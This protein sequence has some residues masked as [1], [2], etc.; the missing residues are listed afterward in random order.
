MTITGLNS[1][2]HHIAKQKSHL[3][4]RCW[5]FS[6]HKIDSND[7]DRENFPATGYRE[8]LL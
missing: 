5:S 6:L 7:S 3:G 1:K 4:A 2:F 8:L